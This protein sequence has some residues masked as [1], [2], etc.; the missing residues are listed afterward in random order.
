MQP[1]DLQRNPCWRPEDLGSSMPDSRHAVS[2]ALPCWRDVIAYEENDPSCRAVLQT[3]YPRFGIHPLLQRLAT[4]LLAQH[5]QAGDSAWL[6]PCLEAASQARY[7]CVTAPTNREGR[8]HLIKVNDLACL[9]TSGSCSIAAKSFWQHAGLGVSSRLA[10]TVLGLEPR[11]DPAAAYIA[12]N[13]LK[14]RIAGVYNCNPD[15]V[16]LHP[17]GMAALHSALRAVKQRCPGRPTLQLGFPYVD[18]LKLPRAVHGGG[19]LLLDTHPDSLAMALDH[20]QPAAVIVELPSNPLLQCVNLSQVSELSRV[21]G[22]PV[23]ADDTIGSAVNIDPLPLVDLVFT[24]LTKSFAGCGDIMAGSLLLSPYSPW[25]Q[26]LQAILKE[27]PIIPLAHADAVALEHAS[28]DFRYRIARQN[29]SCKILAHRLQ[30]HPAIASVY[31]PST[32]RSFHDLMRPGA[33]YGCLL[34]FE[35]HGGTAAASRVYDCL[36]LNKGPSLGTTFSLICPY[37]LLAHYDELDWAA[38]CGLPSHLLRL[39][40]GLEEPDDLWERLKLGLRHGV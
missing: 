20:L 38:H 11:P 28:R 7:H 21:R 17:S 1:R 27:M 6:Y 23:I 34:S 24:S 31:H 18:V 37:V 32:S 13:L 29:R 4:D 12:H 5:G 22:I 30:Q 8:A 33:G 35:L 16:S 36:P 9:I 25:Q 15:Q 3:S 39:S 10:A 26:E 14:Q 2:V 19:E 40:V